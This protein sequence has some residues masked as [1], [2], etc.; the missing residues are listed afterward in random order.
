[1]NEIDICHIDQNAR[2]EAQERPTLKNFAEAFGLNGESGY[3]TARQIADALQVDLSTVQK[4]AKR[5]L[6]NKSI[7][8]I[9]TGGRPAKAYTE[10]EVTAISVSIQSHHNLKIPRSN[11]ELEEDLALI[12]QMK[13]DTEESI[14][15]RKE[16]KEKLERFLSGKS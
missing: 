8:T 12:D 7:K 6:G 16:A 15:R 10:L 13:P 3:M 14:R 11:K 5:L 4:T 1:M 9:Q 2:E